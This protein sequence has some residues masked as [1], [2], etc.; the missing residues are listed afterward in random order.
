MRSILRRI[1]TSITFFLFLTFITSA[2]TAEEERA[3]VQSP[4][5]GLGTAFITHADDVSVVTLHTW[6]ITYTAAK[7]GIS[8]GG[9]IVFHISPF[10]GWTPPQDRDPER[11]GF[12]SIKCSDRSKKL[13]IDVNSRNNYVVIRLKEQPLNHNKQITLIYGD[14]QKKFATAKARSDIYAEKNERLYIKVD[15]DGDGFFTP[16]KTHPKINILSRSAKHFNVTVPSYIEPGKSF[17]V[18]AATLDN[19][20]NWDKSY[21]R[22]IDLK[23]F[24]KGVSCLEIRTEGIGRLFQC[25]TEKKDA[26]VLSAK[27][28]DTAI[29]TV[30]N[31]VVSTKK[32]PPLNL[33]WGDI[34]G[35]SNLSDGTGTPDDYFAYARFAAGL[36]AAILTDHDAWG[37]DR[38]D[39]HPEIWSLI[40]N[41]TAKHHKPDKF[42]TFSGYEYT[43]FTTGHMHVI[44]KEEPA[45][46]LS[47]RDP[48][49]STPNKLWKALKGHEA[50][51]IPHHVGG[52]PIAT[53]WNYYDPKFMPLVEICSIHGNSESIDAPDC[54]YKPV[55]GAFIRDAL[56]RDYKLGIVASGKQ[57]ILD[58]KINNHM[59]GETIT[60]DKHTSKNIEIKITGTD[61]L[62]LVEVIK[63]NTSLEKYSWTDPT[64]SATFT[65][66]SK[67]STNDFT[68]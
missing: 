21:S 17:H 52:G 43:N 23:S 50:I 31:P 1:K 14:T 9:G 45:P 36:D 46:L 49:Y 59:M 40:K 27:N 7:E 24:P 12:V 65:D 5:E 44:F 26:F 29:N 63:N 4:T 30:S 20:D 2:C 64:F 66:D 32:K 11:P 16:I 35:H 3:P 18:T 28:N 34:H 57:I 37:F 47:F 56:A 62:R 68:T 15:G 58:F 54:I 10:W 60:L 41:K 38:L 13:E 25:I 22:T 8:T 55:K 51:T 33:Y 53:N 67:S 42:I 48:A 39:E 61:R 6:K 19:A